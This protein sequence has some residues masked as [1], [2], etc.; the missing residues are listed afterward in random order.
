MNSLAIYENMLKELNNDTKKSDKGE[1]CLIS[2]EQL[3]DTHIKLSCGHKFNYDCILNEIKTQKLKNRLEIQKL[4]TKQTI[5]NQF[6]FVIVDVH[7]E[8]F[9]CVQVLLQKAGSPDQTARPLCR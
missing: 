3:N 1:T 2:N 5:T 4:K 7:V 9:Q 6:V 8:V